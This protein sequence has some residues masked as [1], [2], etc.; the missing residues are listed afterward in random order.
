MKKMLTVLLTL[1]ALNGMYAVV[2]VPLPLATV[3]ANADGGDVL[4]YDSL[5]TESNWQGVA[6]PP[7]VMFALGDPRQ[8]V[9]TVED[10][11]SNVKASLRPSH[12][13]GVVGLKISRD[14]RR[15]AV[16]QTGRF[17]LTNPASGYSYTVQAM[18]VGEEQPEKD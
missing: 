14:D 10:L 12:A 11:P 3:V 9:L 8:M 16:R 6:L 18:V 15:Q 1:T 4:R 13:A 7:E 2:A 17:T 5:Y